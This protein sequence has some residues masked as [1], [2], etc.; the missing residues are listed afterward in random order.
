MTKGVIRV[1][2]IVGKMNGGGVESVVLNYHRRM[3]H[4]RVLFDFLV[5]EDSTRIP[6]GEIEEFGGRIIEIPPYQHLAQ[7]L[8]A[9]ESL[10]RDEKYKI[11]HSHI[12]TLSVFPLFAAYRANVPVRIAHSHSTAGKGELKKNA[13]KYVLRTQSNRYPTHRLACSRY[14]GEWMFGKGKEFDVLPNA[15]ELE[16]FAYRKEVR[17]EVRSMLNLRDSQLVIGHIGRFIPQ[18]NH[19]FLLKLFVDLLAVRS[20]AVLVLAG[21]GENRLSVERWVQEHGIA[22]H[23][24]FLGQ[25]DDV[26]RLYQAFDVFV[27]PSLYE[28]LGLVGVE[29]Q[30]AGLP[31]LFSDRITREVDLTGQS[32]FL[33]ID[34]TKAWVD[35][36]VACKPCSRVDIQPNDFVG[37][38]ISLQAAKL[39][40]YYERS[41]SEVCV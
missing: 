33:S 15:I 36:L 35:A 34:S 16:K 25:R 3:D 20:D 8:K 24:L 28:G 29:A 9:L 31:C 11:V 37:Y 22:E 39:A 10:F 4:K 27:L 26:N 17:D 21:D 30:R 14:A 2:H 18:K 32:R 41:L 6:R 23:V 7:Y 5:D 40:D 38:D 12:N 19:P 1:A 13:L